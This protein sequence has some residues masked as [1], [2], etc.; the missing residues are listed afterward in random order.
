MIGTLPEAVPEKIL[1]KWWVRG[2]IYNLDE[3]STTYPGNQGKPKRH[4]P[5]TGGCRKMIDSE[6]AKRDGIIG[7]MSEPKTGMSNY[8]PENQDLDNYYKWIE[9]MVSNRN[10]LF[11]VYVQ[12]PC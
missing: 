12:V 2:Q 3:G 1:R 4:I 9:M 10:P 6:G 7:Y 5:T 8:T 11:Q